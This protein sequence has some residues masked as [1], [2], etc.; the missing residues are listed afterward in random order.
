MSALDQN[1]DMPF[2]RNEFSKI[3][4]EFFT[5]TSL[6]KMTHSY[7]QTKTENLS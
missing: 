1:Y 5:M 4:E 7:D 2:S 3:L 6:A